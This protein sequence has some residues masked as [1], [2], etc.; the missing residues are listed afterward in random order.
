MKKL[1]LAALLLMLSACAS[2]LSKTT[3]VFE[4]ADFGPQAMAYGLL[5]PKRLPWAP[6][7]PLVIGEGNIYV[8]VYRGIDKSEVVAAYPPDEHRKAD[9]RYVNYSDAMTYLDIKIAQNVLGSVTTRL[10][11]TRQTVVK[12]LGPN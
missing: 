7:T 11:S 10:E 1:V 9:Y 2:R 12:V 5:G 4:Y 8:V 6:E 3:V